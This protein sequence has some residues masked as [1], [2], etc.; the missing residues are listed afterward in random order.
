MR[1]KIKGW[2]RNGTRTF[3]NGV[4]RQKCYTRVVDFQQIEMSPFS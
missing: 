4:G 1:T 2:E 3:G